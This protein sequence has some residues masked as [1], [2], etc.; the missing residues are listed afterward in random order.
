MS[1]GAPDNQLIEEFVSITNSSTYLAEQYLL[2]NN[3]DLVEAVEDFY[4]NNEPTQLS[5]NPDHPQATPHQQQQSGSSRARGSGVR[6]FRDLNNDDEDS[7]DDKTN[8]NFFTGGE[9]QGCRLKIPTRTRTT[10]GP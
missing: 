7:E 10:I 2:R 1:E 6:T 8:T 3:G 4:A 9:S 5:G